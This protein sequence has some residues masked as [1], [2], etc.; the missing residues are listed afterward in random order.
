M[1]AP[2]SSQTWSPALLSHVSQYTS[3]LLRTLCVVIGHLHLKEL[4]LI[5]IGASKAWEPLQLFCN[6]RYQGSVLQAQWLW[7][8][9]RP[10]GRTIGGES[11]LTCASLAMVSSSAADNTVEKKEMPWDSSALWFPPFFPLNF[12]SLIPFKGECAPAAVFQLPP[13]LQVKSHPG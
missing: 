11:L 3:F 4:W 8:K 1:W 10:R 13:A 2:G 9:P 6:W 5:I 12:L 7:E